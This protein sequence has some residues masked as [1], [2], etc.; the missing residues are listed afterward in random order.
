MEQSRDRSN[1]EAAMRARRGVLVWIAVLNVL[2]AVVFPVAVLF[3]LGYIKISILDFYSVLDANGIINHHNLETF[4]GGRFARKW[5][6]PDYL[7]QQLGVV[8]PMCFMASV[9]FL[10]N[11]VA[12]TVCWRRWRR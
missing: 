7:T 4:Q 5:D 11:A 12:A 6:I 1:P 2:A 3:V 8:T 10:A 9:L